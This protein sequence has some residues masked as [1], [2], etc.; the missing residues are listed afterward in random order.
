MSKDKINNIDKVFLPSPKN[1]QRHRFRQT[2][3]FLTSMEQTGVDEFQVP[4]SPNYTADVELQTVTVKVTDPSVATRLSSAEWSA[5]Q[6]GFL[7]VP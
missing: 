1:G 5:R 2:Y 4:T 3:T 7:T 6:L